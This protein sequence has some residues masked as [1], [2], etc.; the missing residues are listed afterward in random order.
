MTRLLPI[1]IGWLLVSGCMSTKEKIRAEIEPLT[2]RVDGLVRQFDLLEEK[3]RKT[4]GAPP[5]KETQRLAKLP[6][7]KG[8]TAAP[9]AISKEDPAER[10]YGTWI[11]EEV[12]TRVGPTV[13]TVT[14]RKDGTVRIDTKSALPLLGHLRTTE[15]PFQVEGDTL[16]SDTIE[17][18]TR[19]HFDFDGDVLVLRTKKDKIIRLHPA[20]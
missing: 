14:F 20:A 1:I 11:S 7:P 15:G 10:L 6:Q 19:M 9:A 8:E 2:E 5:T 3:I 17:G 12:P 18:G 16:S 13:N 4:G